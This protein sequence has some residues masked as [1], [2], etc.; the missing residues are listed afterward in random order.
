MQKEGAD[1]AKWV[2]SGGRSAI[3]RHN[4]IK[5]GLARAICKQ[6]DI[7]APPNPN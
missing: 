6:L 5:P 4:E 7:P 2:S 3:P 1:H